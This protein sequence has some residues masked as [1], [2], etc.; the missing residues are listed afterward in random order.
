MHCKRCDLDRFNKDRSNSNANHHFVNAILSK[1]FQTTLLK[2]QS[3]LFTYM[4]VVSI[5]LCKSKMTIR[6]IVTSVDFD[7]LPPESGGSPLYF[8]TITHKT[9]FSLQYEDDIES[10]IPPPSSSAPSF[11]S[12]SFALLSKRVGGLKKPI[13]ELQ[14]V[15]YSALFFPPTT[16]SFKIKPSHGVLLYGPPGSGKTLLVRSFVEAFHL[17]YFTTNVAS[18]LSQYLGDSEQQLTS[19]FQR[20]REGAPS[21]L[22]LD[23]LDALCPPRENAGPNSTRLCSL[24]LSL[25][26]ELDT[27]VVVVGATNRPQ[28]LDTALRRPGRFDKEIE[29]EV[30]MPS[31]KEEILNV[32]LASLPHALTPAD[33]AFVASHT[34]GFTGADLRLLLTEASLLLL[35]PPNE[36]VSETANET[37]SE[38][39]H[40]D[41]DKGGKKPS[42]IL[43]VGAPLTHP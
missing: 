9:Q 33:V 22:F 24:L 41:T 32:M 38:T 28:G 7:A 3:I 18:L 40:E 16:T 8:A 10:P 31:E 20:A 19:L 26:D 14:E 37:V 2:G 6:G 21:V 36:T 25:F 17:S 30:P 4:G 11:T 42:I 43:F 23:E 27:G 35:D 34:N 13:R 1:F 15:I 12:E 39:T 29:I 5:L